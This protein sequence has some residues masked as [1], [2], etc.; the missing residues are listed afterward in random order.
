[1]CIFLFLVLSE[2]NLDVLIL[3]LGV[4][5]GG[6]ELKYDT[7]SSYDQIFCED[8]LFCEATTVCNTKSVLVFC[9]QSEIVACGQCN[10]VIYLKFGLF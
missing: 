4:Y 9:M 3:C 2:L 5:G 8:P 6:E 10:F 7:V 1:M